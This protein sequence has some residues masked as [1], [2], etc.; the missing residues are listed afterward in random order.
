MPVFEALNAM[1]YLVQILIIISI[2]GCTISAD[3]YHFKLVDYDAKSYDDFYNIWCFTSDQGKSLTVCSSPYRSFSKSIGLIVPIVPQKDRD[4]RL[5]YD[6]ER[7]RVV[8]IQNRD[9][10]ESMLLTNLGQILK[11]GDKYGKACKAE[12]EIRI[13]PGSSAWLILPKGKVHDITVKFK[14]STFVAKLK[15]FIDSKWHAVSV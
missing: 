14:G 6:I 15:E 2:G 8:E 12:R 13:E 11:C 4:S 5:A 3:N 1:R 7:E 9:E 10:S